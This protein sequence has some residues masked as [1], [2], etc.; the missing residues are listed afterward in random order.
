MKIAI[1]YFYSTILFSG[2]YFYPLVKQG[3]PLYRNAKEV[4]GWSGDGL[5]LKRCYFEMVIE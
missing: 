3:F 2:F 4:K 5:L 1:F